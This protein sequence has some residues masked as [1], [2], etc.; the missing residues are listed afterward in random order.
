MVKRL[1]GDGA[2]A[3]SRRARV[4]LGA[5]HHSNQLS[6]AL[7][8]RGRSGRVS[9]WEPGTVHHARNSSEDKQS[10]IERLCGMTKG[11]VLRAQYQP[12]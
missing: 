8:S 2:H 9:D 5:R 1:V 4:A 11:D 6:Y 3:V 10:G 12:G 7:T